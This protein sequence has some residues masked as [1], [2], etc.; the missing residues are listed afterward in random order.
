ELRILA[1]RWQLERIHV[2]DEYA[3]LTYRNARRIEALARL[4]PRLVRIV[5][6]KSAYIPLEEKRPRGSV[7]AAAVRPL[8]QATS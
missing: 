3:V 5:D 6:E 7:V 2:E 1:G 4:H 8:L